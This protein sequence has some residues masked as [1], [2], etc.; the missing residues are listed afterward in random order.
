MTETTIDAKTF[1]ELPSIHPDFSEATAHI[2]A[3]SLCR[4]PLGREPG[5]LGNV[6]EAKR[7]ITSKRGMLDTVRSYPEA[8]PVIHGGIKIV[9]RG[10]RQYSNGTVVLVDAALADG[11]QTQKVLGESGADVLV[12]ANIIMVPRGKSQ[13]WAPLLGATYNTH[14]PV[15]PLSILGKQGVFDDLEVAVGLAVQKSETDRE[16]NPDLVD[17][18]LLV[19]FTQAYMGRERRVGG[20][21]GLD[22]LAKLCRATTGP[23]AAEYRL[24]LKAAPVAWRL[25]EH[26]QTATTFNRVRAFVPKHVNQANVHRGQPRTGLYAIPALYAYGGCGGKSFEPLTRPLIKLDKEIVKYWLKVA[27]QNYAAIQQ[28]ATLTGFH[29]EGWAAHFLLWAESV[30]R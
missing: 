16:R 12:R 7:V 22:H 9:C 17:T 26:V 15:H 14:A 27:R 6:R 21:T 30:A 13:A 19:K 28:L 29:R 20:K 10:Y 1:V 5:E 25:G 24:F 23:D 18:Q 11:A 2:T 4:I 8:F 3:Q